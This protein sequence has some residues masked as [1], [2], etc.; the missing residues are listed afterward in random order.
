M[1]RVMLIEEEGE[2]EAHCCE[3]GIKEEWGWG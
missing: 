2:G 1:P 3:D